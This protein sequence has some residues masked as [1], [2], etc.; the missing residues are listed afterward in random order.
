MTV[1]AMI[2]TGLGI[3][4]RGIMLL[5]SVGKT[6]SH[7]CAIGVIPLRCGRGCIMSGK[8]TRAVEVVSLFS[9]VGVV[10]S[11]VIY[12]IQFTSYGL[13]YISIASL[14]DILRDSLKLLILFAAGFLCVMPVNA[15]A[16]LKFDVSKLSRRLIATTVATFLAMILMALMIGTFVV[17]GAASMSAEIG[18]LNLIFISLL[19]GA[20]WISIFSTFR[21]LPEDQKIE[22]LGPWDHKTKIR[23]I[24]GLCVWV[25][26]AAGFVLILMVDQ[27]GKGLPMTVEIDGVRSCP[28]QGYRA[29][30]IGEGKA[31][32]K[33]D[34][35]KLYF[36]KVL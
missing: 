21:V 32:L 11:V 20:L 34:K 36:V 25:L 31:V 35:S 23:V 29:I 13:N 8:I 24:V 7:I 1:A 14:S 17:V 16:S 22:L 9:A 10:A 30:W 2:H 15:I 33:C 19:F 5:F 6:S 28:D 27:M 3:E 12:S 26:G 18:S 4:G